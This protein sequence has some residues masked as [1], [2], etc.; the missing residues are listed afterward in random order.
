MILQLCFTGI[1]IV[2]KRSSKPRLTKE[3]PSAFYGDTGERIS[4]EKPDSAAL[5]PVVWVIDSGSHDSRGKSFRIY[6]GD[7]GTRT[8]GLCR[9][10][11]AF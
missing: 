3:R 9:D 10:R 4:R 7:D 5:K 11:A 2:K 6:G 1:K 8:R